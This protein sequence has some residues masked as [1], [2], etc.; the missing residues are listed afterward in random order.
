MIVHGESTIACLVLVGLRGLI[1]EEI[2]CFSW[3]KII[4]RVEWREQEVG[5]FE[6]VKDMGNSR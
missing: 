3:C 1:C 6:L 4:Q 2:L 5:A